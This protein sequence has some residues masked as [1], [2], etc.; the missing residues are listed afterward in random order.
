M[1]YLITCELHLLVQCKIELSHISLLVAIFIIYFHLF[2][3]RYLLSRHH[4]HN[5]MTHYFARLVYALLILR[6]LNL[7]FILCVFFICIVYRK[8]ILKLLFYFI[9]FVFHVHF[10]H[11]IEMSTFHFCIWERLSGNGAI[12]PKNR[13]RTVTKYQF[14][15]DNV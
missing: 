8:V 5:G 9:S 4:F 6:T 12:L 13:N 15:D 3:H 1:K 10:R 11:R 14:M 2:I 7:H